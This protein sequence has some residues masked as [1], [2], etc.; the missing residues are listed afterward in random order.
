MAVENV[1]LFVQSSYRWDVF[2]EAPA[3]TWALG[4]GFSVRLGD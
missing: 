2:P 4:G 1:K 3:T